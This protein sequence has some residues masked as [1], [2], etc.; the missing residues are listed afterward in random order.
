MPAY[1]ISNCAQLPSDGA[2]DRSILRGKRNIFP[3]AT[4]DQIRLVI[5]IVN[6]FQE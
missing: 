4:N 1:S 6:A 3:F 2:C 5:F